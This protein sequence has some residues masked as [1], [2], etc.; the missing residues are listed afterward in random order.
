MW[1]LEEKCKNIERTKKYV[2]DQDVEGWGSFFNHQHMILDNHFAGYWPLQNQFE[3]NI[4][5]P[6]MA[7]T[8][9]L[10][11]LD[12]LELNNLVRPQQ[13]DIYMGP[14]LSHVVEARWQGNLHEL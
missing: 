3:S 4:G 7:S 13:R 14:G 12:N 11:R 10:Q 2:G 5:G 1:C 9:R 8:T 6:S